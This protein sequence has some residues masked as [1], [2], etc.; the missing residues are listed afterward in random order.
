MNEIYGT[1]LA[2]RRAAGWAAFTKF[3]SELC[4]HR[5]PLRM[6]IRLFEAVVSPCVLYA[7][8]CWAL[9]GDMERQLQ[10]NR[11]KMM[12][13]VV[14]V[15]RRKLLDGSLEPWIDYVQ[16]AT[17][18]AEDLF[19]KCGSIEWTEAHRRR[20]WNLAGRLARAADS[21]WGKKMLSWLPLHGKG[22]HVGRPKTRW[23][24]DLEKFAGGNWA[25]EALDAVFWHSLADGFAKNI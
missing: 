9:T 12:R 1:E 19:A 8:G 3:R 5:W 13:L 2:S 10:T 11:R 16:R 15:G 14:R 22:R 18:T 23:S 17:H 4:N 20:K 6:R 25:Q 24:Y 21:R 7:S